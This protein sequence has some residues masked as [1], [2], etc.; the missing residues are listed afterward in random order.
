MKKTT[1][2][3]AVKQQVKHYLRLKGW[4]VFHNLAG[5]GCYP[6]ISDFTAIKDGRTVWIEVKTPT[7]KQSERQLMFQEHVEGHGGEYVIIKSLED[8]IRFDNDPNL[9]RLL[10]SEVDSSSSGRL[11]G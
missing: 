5:L 11:N 2:E 7:G 1:G 3:T 10:D 4:L 6:G 9:V 8:A